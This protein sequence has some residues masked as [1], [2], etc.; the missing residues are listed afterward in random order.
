MCWSPR[1]NMWRQSLGCRKWPCG[2]ANL[3]Q[4]YL[5]FYMVIGLNTLLTSICS[6]KE[7]KG[8][9][10]ILPTDCSL[11]DVR[12]LQGS[13]R[14]HTFFFCSTLS[15]THT[16]TQI[17]HLSPPPQWVIG[18]VSEPDRYWLSLP[19]IERQAKKTFGKEEKV[20]LWKHVLSWL[21]KLPLTHSSGDH[22]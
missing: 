6:M 10:E 7:R 3:S 8:A 4:D 2:H 13:P 17:P 19:Q 15:R 1:F 21:L 5:S 20:R 12:G 11:K 9:R 14:R 22:P 16:D 18:D